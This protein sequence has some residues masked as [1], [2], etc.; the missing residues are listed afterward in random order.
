MDIQMP[1][2]DGLKATRI[3]REKE[4]ARGGHTIII[5]VTAF[6]DP[7]DRER[8]LSSGMDAYLCKP[9]DLEELLSLLGKE[10]KNR[11]GTPS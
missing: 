9:I 8:C 3:I 10:G 4:A 1:L 7:T 6:A 2:M 5:A 11:P